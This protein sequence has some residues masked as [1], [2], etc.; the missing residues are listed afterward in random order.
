MSLGKLDHYSIRTSRLA[1][2]EHFYTDVLGLQTGPRPEFKF[3]GIW[4]HNAGQAVVHVVAIDRA[5]PQPL[6]DYLGEKA[7]EDADDTG[8]IDHIAFVAQDLAGMQARFN[9]AGYAF[10][11]R[12]VPS[13]NLAQIFLEDPNGVTAEY[14]SGPLNIFE[15]AHHSPEALGAASL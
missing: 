5:N 11:E 12:L 1:Q 10:R 14:L 8:S 7:L 3:P 2:I 6:I 13:L 4:L 15:A 9:E